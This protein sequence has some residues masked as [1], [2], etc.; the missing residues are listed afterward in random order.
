MVAETKLYDVLGVKPDAPSDVI[1]KAYYKL[2]QKHHPDK[3][4]NDDSDAKF[5]E[6]A[7]A[8]EVLSDEK[9]RQSYDRYG[10]NKPPPTM[11]DIFGNVFGGS[12][13][14]FGGFTQKE[15]QHIKIDISV[16]LEEVYNKTPKTVSYKRVIRCTDCTGNGVKHGANK[17]QCHHC[18][19]TGRVQITRM[20]GPGM[21]QQMISACDKCGG[22]GHSVNAADRCTSC[23]DGQKTVSESIVE[24]LK[25][26]TR[27]F[28]GKGNL[29]G[30][31]HVVTH[32]SKH[33]LFSHTGDDLHV[34]V[35]IPLR[36][37][38]KGACV[39]LSFLDGKDLV[40]KSKPETVIC[41][42]DTFRVIGKGLGVRG[43]LYVKF[44]L[45]FPKFEELSSV[46]DVV[47]SL[48]GKDS[49]VCYVDEECIT[50]E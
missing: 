31:L 20:L 7:S 2:A 16:T 45:V 34:T 1:K 11:D 43:H 22:K 21:M 40:L 28:P 9:K 5:K 12:F 27:V 38:F 6:I 32:I 46:S 33:S 44:N 8:Y 19:G 24:A 36:D 4:K 42:N 18:K 35:D 30:D 39:T 50:L 47:N 26:G 25:E 23:K 13:G 3:N 15:A 10:S 48:P 29:G 41:P 17:A 49:D 37:A 14:G